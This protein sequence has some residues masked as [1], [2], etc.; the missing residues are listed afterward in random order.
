[1]DAGQ[2]RLVNRYSGLVLGLSGKT[3]RLAETT[4]L[5][6]WTDTTGS[7]V[8]EGRTAAEQTLTFT[9]AGAGTLGGIHT[10]AASGKNLDDPDSSTATGTPLVTWAPHQGENQK[11][12]FTRQAGGSYTLTNAHSKLCADVEGGSTA[13]GARVIQW[14]CTGGPNQ[15]WTAA[16]QP[17]GRYKLAG[18]R[19]GLLLTTASTSDGAAVTHR[20]DT[21]SALQLWTI[22]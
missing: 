12:L 22:G 21:G 2:F 7:T 16:K 13:A 19:S 9:D 4:P 1:M 17:D 20:A 18:V 6:S 10:L 14:T 3:S 15:R 8:G 11:W 5:R